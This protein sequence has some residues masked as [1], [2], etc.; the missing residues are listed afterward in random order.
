MFLD[1]FKTD[2]GGV[3]QIRGWMV[4]FAGYAPAPVIEAVNPPGAGKQSLTAR[5]HVFKA[6]GFMGLNDADATE[7]TFAALAESVVEALDDDDTLHGG[8]Y[9]ECSP[10]SIDFFGT[11]MLGGVLCNH[12]EIRL[13]VTEAVQI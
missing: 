12:A 2:I 6:M 8:T 3:E 10:A 11:L 5:A 13:T 4:S 9:L 1:Q 7:K